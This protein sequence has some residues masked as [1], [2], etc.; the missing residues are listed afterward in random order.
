MKKITVVILVLMILAIALI[1]FGVT[2]VNRSINSTLEPLQNVNKQLGTQVSELLHPTPTIIPDPVTII[3][4]VQALA[5]LET[6]RYT[7][8]G[9]D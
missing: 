7:I 9:R 5:R 6:I 2:M 1:W 4:E 8:E 3:N